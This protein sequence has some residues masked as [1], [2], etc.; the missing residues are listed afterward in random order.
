MKD[1]NPNRPAKA[2][3][4]LPTVEHQ[5]FSIG[6]KLTYR[7]HYGIIDA[8]EATLSVN[9]SSQK[10][11]GRSIYHIVGEGKSISAFDWFFKVRDRY[12]TYLDQDGVFPWVFVRRVNEGG[13]EISQDYTFHQ[14]KEKVITQDDKSYEVP[15]GVQDM[16]SA[17]YY[18]RTLDF[19]DVQEGDTFN[20][21]C[22]MDNEI[23]P[24]T[25]KYV[26]KE[27]KRIRSGKYDCMV[28]R[29]VVQKGRIFKKEEDLTVWITDDENRI[30][31]LAKANILVGSIKMEL[32]EYEGLVNPISKVQKKKK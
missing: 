27:Q 20:V 17:F 8:G 5:A 2:I 9:E 12:E 24:L 15:V 30:P 26:G 6:E 31:I 13:H 22:F 7:L 11:R 4:Q 25:I 14:H 3:K 21:T 23:Y 19:S 18:A 16:L 1:S 10:V 32:T 29:P 28:F